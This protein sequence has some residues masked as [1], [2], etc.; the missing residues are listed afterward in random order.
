M[1]R[2]HFFGTSQSNG[3]EP[4]ALTVLFLFWIYTSMIR[5][6]LE[7]AAPV[8]HTSLS[9]EQSERLESVQKRV[10]R[11]VY[12][13]LSY[14]GALSLTGMQTLHQRR[15]DTAREFFVQLLQ[16]GHKLHYPLP[17]PRD[18]GY[19]L[20]SLPK[21]PRVGKTKRFSQHPGALWT[22]KLAAAHELN[23]KFEP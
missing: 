17:Q 14:R 2:L 18:I 12:P 8:C 19:S 22:Y 11:V 16:P 6:V 4:R 10:L 1:C 20:R 13:D 15:E 23:L 5:A 7:Y 9:Q 21:Y 3:K